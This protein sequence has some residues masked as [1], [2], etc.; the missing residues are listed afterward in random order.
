MEVRTKEQIWQEILNAN[1]AG[2]E[3]VQ[4]KKKVM[5]GQ[6]YLSNFDAQKKKKKEVKRLAKY[7]ARLKQQSQAMTK[8]KNGKTP[9]SQKQIDYIEYL[10]SQS[11]RK[12]DWNYQ[13]DKYVLSQKMAGAFI[14]A[15]KTQ[16]EFNCNLYNKQEYHLAMINHNQLDSQFLFAINNDN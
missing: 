7:K 11:K 3:Y 1:P 12:Y 6:D 4:N 14:Q 10:L 9:A 16:K 13:R 5:S 15:I 2:Q 8:L